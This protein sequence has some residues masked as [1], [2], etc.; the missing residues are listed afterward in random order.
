MPLFFFSV[1]HDNGPN[2]CNDGAEFSDREAAWKE[3][4]R[5]FSE[6]VVG[7]SRKLGENSSWQMELL[8]ASRQPIFRIR[9]VAETLA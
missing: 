5:V 8:D 3:L 2:I 4:T 1:E 6:M 7:V 9:L